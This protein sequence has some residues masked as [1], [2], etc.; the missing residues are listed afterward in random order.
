MDGNK[1]KDNQSNIKI[2][3]RQQQHD[4]NT[5]TENNEKDKHLQ[6]QKR[7]DLIINATWYGLYKVS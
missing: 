4:V 3:T 2:P 1:K 7:L 5:T 6:L